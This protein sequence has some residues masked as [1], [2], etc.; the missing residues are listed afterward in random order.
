MAKESCLNW[1]FTHWPQKRHFMLWPPGI[2]RTALIMLE[3]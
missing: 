1:P 3:T 2:F